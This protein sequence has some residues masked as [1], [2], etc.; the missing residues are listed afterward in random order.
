MLQHHIKKL[1]IIQQQDQ[2]IYNTQ[3]EMKVLLI[4]DMAALNQLDKSKNFWI[5]KP[6]T[7]LIIVIR[8]EKTLV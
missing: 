2:N 3:A 5:C 6:R 1:D 4:D 8:N 7:S